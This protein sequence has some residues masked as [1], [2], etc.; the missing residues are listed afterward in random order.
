MSRKILLLGGSRYALP[1][2]DT[3]HKLD[4]KVYTCDYLPKNIA[5]KYSDGYENISIVDKEAVLNIAKKM[6]VDGIM[7]FACDP[8]VVTAAYVAEK[9]GL[10]SAGSYKSVCIL[11]NK[12]KF[13]KLLLDNGFNV[14][15]ARGYKRIGDALEQMEEFLFP[16]IVK[17]TD[18]A[19]SKGVTKVESV[20]GMKSAI[21][22]ALGHSIDGEFIVEK[23][24]ESKG[25]PSDSECFS[26]DGELKFVSYS[27][28]G[29]DGECGNP[30]APTG[31]TWVP[32]I[33][34]PHQKELSSE[35]QRLL[36]ILGMR[37]SLYNVETRESI[38]GKAYIMEVSPRGGGNRLAEML[39]YSTGV[40][41][42]ELAVKAALGDTIGEI[43]D[44]TINDF[45]AEIILHSKKSGH[46]K[47]LSISEELKKYIVETDIWVAEG[48]LVENF[49]GAN[50]AV[51]TLILR[52]DD[53]KL[54]SQV[55]SKPSQYVFVD[56]G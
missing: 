33:S 50:K 4:C 8:G 39:R 2:I 53:K 15:M 48:D 37:T 43:Q 32:T 54:M 51:G 13:R 23:F 7:S 10:P 36:R 40:D 46:Y 18:S 56:V 6:K 35:L 21:D 27:S 38:D 30:Y 29:F 1:V 24:L 11:Q 20:D 34:E 41:L 12:K 5:H 31:F 3:A 17:P 9:M 22:H 25:N 52:F 42:I 19:G 55:M 16:V 26:I 44:Y 45:W 49:S 28:Q 14:P 47:G